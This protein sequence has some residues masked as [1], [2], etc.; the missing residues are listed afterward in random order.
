MH[1][2]HEVHT[3]HLSLLPGT[4]H[5]KYIDGGNWRHATDQATT[6]DDSGNLNNLI[7]VEPAAVEFDLDHSSDSDS[8]AAG[9]PAASPPSGGRRPPAADGSG[10]S[11]RAS[12]DCAA[13]EAAV[14]EPPALPPH[15]RTPS[16]RSGTSTGCA[17]A[18]AG[19]RGDACGHVRLNHLF[20]AVPY[21]G[22]CCV[23]VVRRYQATKRV[24]S[25]VYLA[26][27]EVNE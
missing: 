22:V 4:Y 14:V 12:Y 19:T 11:P 5:Y 16:L 27:A 2:H 3:A 20:I 13:P 8:A 21:D 6:L 10:A 18:P 23:G 26:E 25:L 17:K 1:R 15:L 7:T 9:A 24:T